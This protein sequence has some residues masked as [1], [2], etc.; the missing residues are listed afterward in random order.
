MYV[1]KILPGWPDQ[2]PSLSLG[3][4]YSN[5]G[6]PPQQPNSRSSEFTILLSSKGS[7][8]S[9]GIEGFYCL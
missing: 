4:M 8:F 2:D 3:M 7:L 5:S 6:A 1:S 9:H